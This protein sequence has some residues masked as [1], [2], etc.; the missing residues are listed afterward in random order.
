MRHLALIIIAAAAL[1]FPLGSAAQGSIENALNAFAASKTGVE[2]LSSHNQKDT[3]QGKKCIYQSYEFEVDRSNSQWKQLLKAFSA[4]EKNAYSVFAKNDGT[5]DRSTTKVC[6][7]PDPAN[8]SNVVT[9]GSNLSHNY[10]VLLFRDPADEYWRTCYAVAWYESDEDSKNFHGYAYKIYSRDPRRAGNEQQQTTV[11][12]LND[13]SVVQYDN[14][15]GKSTIVQAGESISG[16]D[17]ITSGTDFLA[18]F[19]NLRALFLRYNNPKKTDLNKLPMLTSIVNK[20]M[21]LCK[22]NGKLLNSDEKRVVSDMLG[23]MQ[24]DCEDIG[25]NGMVGLAIKYLK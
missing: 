1:A 8:N 6:F 17:N 14:N 15:T 4:D 7:G 21:V 12:M 18:R 9:F 24:Q 13:G 10:R 5:T 2:I 3:D 16:N 22:Q 25:L 20:I 23:N 19:N 11:A